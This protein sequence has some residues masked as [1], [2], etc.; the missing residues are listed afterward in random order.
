MEPTPLL[1]E[2]ATL[3]NALGQRIAVLRS[4]AGLSI[5]DLA[6]ITKI[7]KKYLLALETDSPADL[8]D[9]MYVR[10]FLRAVAQVLR[11]SPDTL[12]ALYHT[13]GDEP[14]T[15][16]TPKPPSRLAF[17]VPSRILTQIGIGAFVLVVAIVLLFQ[18]RAIAAPP[19]LT[20]MSPAE[21][22]ALS[23]P[24]T[25]VSG[26]VARGADVTINGERVVPDREGRFA[27]DIDLHEG[28]NLIKIAAKKSHSGERVVYRQVIVDTPTPATSTP[29]TP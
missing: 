11:V 24:F 28:I 9:P 8:P 23:D 22:A 26:Q 4:A 17:I 13:P 14:P 20:I 6:E 19:E 15:I 5:A 18:I 10:H 29:R 12:L 16:L 27:V 3:P 2:E 21:S 7:Q 1:P 25:T